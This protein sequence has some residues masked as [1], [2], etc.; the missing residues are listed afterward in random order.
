M[1]PHSFEQ[2]HNNFC[3]LC[4]LSLPLQVFVDFECF[5]H[6]VIFVSF[7]GIEFMR[8]LFF[9][10]LSTC[11]FFAVWSFSS[12]FV[13]CV[14]AVSNFYHF[15]FVLVWIEVHLN[16]KLNLL[17]CPL[18][19]MRLLP[20]FI[21][22]VHLFCLMITLKIKTHLRIK[23]LKMHAKNKSPQMIGKSLSKEWSFNLFLW[24][25]LLTST[26]IPREVTYYLDE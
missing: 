3:F 2:H 14:F 26:Q 20:L 8:L 13:V 6:C 18:C 10:R 16:W 17:S 22:E 11:F 23:T 25:R 19:H 7:I 12:H 1:Y 9:A 4:H 5:F 21:S 24:K 15:F